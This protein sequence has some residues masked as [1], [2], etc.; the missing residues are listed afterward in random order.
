[1]TVI[2]VPVASVTVLPATSSVAIGQTT[3][4]TA[5]LTDA[6]GNTLSGRVV[7]WSSSQTSIAT[8]SGTGVVTGVSGGTAT[9]TALSEGQTGTATVDV[10]APGVRTITIV[11]SSATIAVLGSITL[12]ATVRDPSGAI[13]NAQ[14]SWSSN[15]SLVASV[16]SNG[17]VNGLLPG[18]ATITAKS[19]SATATATITVQ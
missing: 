17:T 5:T 11:P 8:V 14:V 19:G 18:T 9:I 12:T 3:Q 15:N 10:V 16:S 1:V 7:T 4:L 6:S 13:I 2:S